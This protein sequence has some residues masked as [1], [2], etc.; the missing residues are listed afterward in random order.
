MTRAV[1]RL[2]VSGA[3]DP[4]RES[5][6]D[7]PIGWVIDRLDAAGELAAAGGEPVEL[8]R[9]GSQWLVR[10][11]RHAD[12]PPEAAHE[13]D[14]VLEAAQLSLFD[15]L[16]AVGEAAAPVLPA[17]DPL[18]LPPLHVPRRL[19]Y[20]AIALFESCSY[21]YYAQRVLGLRPGAQPRP[22]ADGDGGLAA[23][24]IGDAAHRLLELV[25]LDEP[26]PPPPGVLGD[27]VRSWY[28][29]VTDAE[30]AR[31]EAFV[32]AY[33][34]SS[35]ARRIA[36]LPGARPERPFA[37]EHDGVLLH[38]RLDVLALSDG[39]ALVV[40]YKTNVLGENEPAA[41][42]EAEYRLQRLV[43]ALACLR[44]GAVEVEVVYAFLERPE[45]VASATFTVSDT[46]EL[47][48]ELSAAIRRIAEGDFHPT[49]SDFSCADCPALNLV[50]A[51][52]RLRGGGSWAPLP[53]LTAAG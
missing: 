7:T 51:G 46:P 3:I 30:L 5:D 15:D 38:G 39:R 1:D 48:R 12:R 25:P 16:P 31:I 34:S 11:D 23:T 40:D 2:I 47:E 24:E 13:V 37:F 19:S 14:A 52:P 18:P 45:D 28:P 33:C 32:A 50:C 4:D 53:E 8:E 27:T 44:A 17:L 6:R 49:P 42:V 29:A 26:V 22:G 10:V 43:Y 35:L 20:S 21:R 41:V 9:A 36:T